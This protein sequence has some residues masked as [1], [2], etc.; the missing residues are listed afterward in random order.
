MFRQVSITTDYYKLV[1]AFP[2]VREAF[3]NVFNLKIFGKW[4]KQ[5]KF[6]FWGKKKFIINGCSN[7]FSCK[8]IAVSGF[9]LLSGPFSGC[10][11]VGF[12]LV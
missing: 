4:L 8:G 9:G 5:R 11:E 1:V 10:N 7:N 2:G 3:I 12:Y 6:I